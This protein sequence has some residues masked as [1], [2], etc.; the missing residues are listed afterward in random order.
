MKKLKVFKY[1]AGRQRLAYWSLAFVLLGSLL[2]PSSGQ[3]DEL[4]ECMREMMQFADDTTTIGELR[5]RCQMR[6]IYETSATEE[7]QT[8]V[9]TKRVKK[10]KE[11][12]L[13]PFTLMSHKPN[14]ILF[15]AHNLNGYNPEF[16]RQAEGDPSVE[17]DDTEVQFQISIKMPLAVDLWNIFDI[18]AAYTNHSFWQLYDS[19]SSPFRETNHEPEVWVEFQPKWKLLGLTNR[20][21]AFGIVHQSNGRG[22]VRS[23]SWN[24]LYAN[25]E[26]ERGPLA[27][28]F[29]PWYRLQE[30]SADD[31][32]PDITDYLGHFEM[33]AAYKWKEHVFS[34]MSRNN[35]ESG[36]SKGALEGSWSFPLGSY[37]YLKGYVQ[38]FTGYGESLIDYNHYVNKIG[39]GLT[40]TDWL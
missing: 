18:Y 3:A 33:R 10:A 38:C 25:F 26:F 29:K 40:L 21:N 1:Q 13:Q 9:L 22:N 4:T 17:L 14:F 8:P 36:F 34:V 5:S 16:Y 31:D 23:R 32:N 2:A 37:P 27:L 11:N 20:V 24:R 30:D 12:V 39:A 35:L 19:D 15:A 28:G 7:T 6:M